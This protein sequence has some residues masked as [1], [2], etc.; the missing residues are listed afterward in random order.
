VPAPLPPPELAA[1][2]GDSV[3]GFDASGRALRDDVERLLGPEWSWE[4]KR[5]LDFGCGPGR[6]L[7]QF[8]PEAQRGRWV[9]ADVHQPSLAWARTALSPPVELARSPQAPPLPFAPESFDLVLSM[10]VISHL[11]DD[12]AAWMLDLRRVLAPGGLLLTTIISAGYSRTLTGEP[13]DETRVGMNVLGYGAPRAA[14]GPMILHSGWWVRAHWGRAF[15]IL[16]L[17]ESED[18]EAPEPAGRGPDASPGGRADP[19]EPRELRAL[20]H[21]LAQTRRERA[22]L[23][24]SHDQYAQAYQAAFAGLPVWRPLEPERGTVHGCHLYTLLVDDA[25]PR[26]RD[27]VLAALAEWKIGAGVHYTALHTHPYYA[28]ALGHEPGD[29]PNALE[30]GERTFSIPLS[31]KLTDEDVE[32]VVAAVCDALS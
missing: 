22:E 13:W 24:R 6:L 20:A 11:V 27:D 18:L 3:E 21:N 30:I 10:S 4:G 5:V 16:A 8:L 26:S 9:G 15:E 7:R 17:E 14:G 19:D 32:D 25:A 2:V 28:R 29:F 12:W 31:P 1:Y 23:N